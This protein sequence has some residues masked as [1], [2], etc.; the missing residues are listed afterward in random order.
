MVG[1]REKIEVNPRD[2]RYSHVTFNRLKE[3]IV[4]RRIYF[5][6]RCNVWEDYVTTIGVFYK[7]F[8]CG[9]C[10]VKRIHE[11]KVQIKVWYSREDRGKWELLEHCL[12]LLKVMGYKYVEIIQQ[13][14]WLTK[15]LDNGW[16]MDSKYLTKEL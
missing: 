9:G 14:K 2:L 12:E 10:L 16:V 15:L 6:V 5:D 13:K 3:Y 11:E 1:V 8:L 4:G 7:G